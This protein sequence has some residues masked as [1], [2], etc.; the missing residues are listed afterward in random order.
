MLNNEVT[1]QTD[2]LERHLCHALDKCERFQMNESQTEYLMGLILAPEKDFSA[3]DGL[4]NVWQYQ[5]LIKRAE[6]CLTATFDNRVLF[7][8]VILC[9][10]AIGSC[11]MYLYY[12]QYLAKKKGLK[13]VSFEEFCE[14]FF[15]M[16]FMSDEDLHKVWDDCKVKREGNGR[17]NLIDYGQASLSIQ[18]EDMIKKEKPTE[19]PQSMNK[20]QAEGRAN[21]SEKISIS[22]PPKNSGWVDVFYKSDPSRVH[23]LF[24]DFIRKKFVTKRGRNKTHR[25]T[26][27]R[28][29]NLAF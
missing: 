10:G 4:K 28:F 18:F 6:H 11:I 14:K 12:I 5:A 20:S 23:E 22:N 7:F 1:K 16:G 19:K 26:H 17:D 9:E 29:K 15:P 13:H 3:Q 2:A 24:Y 25:I 27:Y 21:R 8:I